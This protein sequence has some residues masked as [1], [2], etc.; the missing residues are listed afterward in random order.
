MTFQNENVIAEHYGVAFQ[1]ENLTNR[2]GS[3]VSSGSYLVLVKVKES[4]GRMKLQR[5]LLGVQR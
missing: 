5:S 1:N 4:D 3:K 2:A